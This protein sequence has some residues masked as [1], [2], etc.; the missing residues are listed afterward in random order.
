M[1][2]PLNSLLTERS[3]AIVR[4]SGGIN[5][6]EAMLS[7][8]ITETLQDGEISELP[9]LKN[10]CAKVSVQLS[11]KLD[12]ICDILDIHKRSFIETAFIDAILKAEE[13]MENE[14]VFESLENRRI[15]QEKVDAAYA[16]SQK[17][18]V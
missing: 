16:A 7:G 17:G 5:L 4:Q 13:I 10:V 12:Y 1:R 8:A 2:R 9:Q 15:Q 6:I 11:D 3:L 14:G 18:G